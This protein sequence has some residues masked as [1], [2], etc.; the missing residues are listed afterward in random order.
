MPHSKKKESQKKESQKKKYADREKCV[1]IYGGKGSKSK[2]NKE[3]QGCGNPST[4]NTLF[5]KFHYAAAKNA[6]YN[7]LKRVFEEMPYGPK[8]GV[9]YKQCLNHWNFM[10]PL[11][12]IIKI[13][14]EPDY[15][16]HL[17]E[18]QHADYNNDDVKSLQTEI[19]L[20]Y[21]SKEDVYCEI[22]SLQKEEILTIFSKENTD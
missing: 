11:Y 19:I 15:I 17:T 7:L 14:P 2:P 9:V 5:C 18:Y 13:C 22:D 8:F 21:L 20:I 4:I 6:N 10:H 16:S 12:K 3:G 1:W